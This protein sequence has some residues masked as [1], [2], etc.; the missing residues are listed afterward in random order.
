MKDFKGVYSALMTPFNADGSVDYEALKAL[1][2]YCIS[3]GVTG[4]YDSSC[5]LPCLS[6]SP[7]FL[8]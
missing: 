7:D 8:W 5:F 3:S 6:S 2:K 1:S 4:L